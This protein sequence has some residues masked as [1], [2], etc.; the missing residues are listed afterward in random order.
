MGH[1][2][3]HHVPDGAVTRQSAAPL[4]P[5][6]HPKTSIVVGST[7]NCPSTARTQSSET[8]DMVCPR[9]ANASYAGLEDEER[10]PRTWILTAPSLTSSGESPIFRAL[11]RN[12]GW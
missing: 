5:P 9:A 6:W 12:P 4:N 1:A 11:V 8:A 10:F 7:P 3:R 2:F